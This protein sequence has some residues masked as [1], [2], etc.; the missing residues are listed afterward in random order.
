MRINFSPCKC[1]CRR[2]VVSVGGSKL[3]CWGCGVIVYEHNDVY[4]D[5]G[6]LFSLLVMVVFLAMVF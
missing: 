2:P 5:I 6:A 4:E 1:G 3:A